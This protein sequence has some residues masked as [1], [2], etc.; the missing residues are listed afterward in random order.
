VQRATIDERKR[1]PEDV[2]G[3]EW[4]K[5]ISRKIQPADVKGKEWCTDKLKY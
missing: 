5:N 3:K 1:Q 2:K 4:C